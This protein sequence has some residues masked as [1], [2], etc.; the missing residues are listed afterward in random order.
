MDAK[1]LMIPR[2]EVMAFY[3]GCNSHNIYEIGSVLTDNG[4]TA[5]N[6]QDGKAVF[7]IDFEQYPHLFRKLN[8]WEYRTVEQ[9][10]QKL[11]CNALYDDD[12]VHFI[13]VW[14]MDNLFGYTDKANRKGC[15]LLSFEPEFGYFPVD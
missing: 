10:P 11:K 12:T 5:V 6:D 1:E 13:E 2:F 7:P 4:K 3:P 9:M 8:W 14:D 15:G